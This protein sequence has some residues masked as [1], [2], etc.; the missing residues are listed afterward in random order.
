MGAVTRGSGDRGEADVALGA[1]T[2]PEVV[3]VI[4]LQM[5]ATPMAVG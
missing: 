1:K 2:S 3:V 4:V 5:Q